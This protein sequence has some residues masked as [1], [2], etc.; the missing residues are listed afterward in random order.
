MFITSCFLILYCLTNIPQFE[1]ELEFLYIHVL[2]FVFPKRQVWRHSVMFRRSLQNKIRT[3]IPYL[4]L[5]HS[6]L[7]NELTWEIFSIL[8]W[9]WIRSNPWSQNGV[10]FPERFICCGGFFY[11][12]SVQAFHQIP[13]LMCPVQYP[14]GKPAN[15]F[16]LIYPF[17]AH[18]L[19]IS[20][21]N[22]WT[23]HCKKRLAIFP[24]PAGMSLTKLSLA[25]NNLI[26]PDQGEFGQ[27]HPGGGQENG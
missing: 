22:C 20:P 4:F 17:L 7:Q 10:I 21:L 27:W 25:G 24:S 13:F 12:I 15:F 18:F 3:Q 14:K 2:Y 26:F 1:W 6:M 9:L 5:N 19:N 8:I 16:L 23:V 11:N